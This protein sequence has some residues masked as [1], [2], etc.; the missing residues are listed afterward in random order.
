MN[1]I[2]HELEVILGPGTAE[3]GL[4]L[5]VHSGP[6]TAGVLRGEKSRFQLFGDTVNTAARMESTGERNKIQ[7]SQKT[8]ELLIAA[9][10]GEWIKPRDSLVVAKGKGK[11]QTFWLS[12]RT[13]STGSQSGSHTNSTSFLEQDISSNTGIDEV[14]PVVSKIEDRVVAANQNLVNWYVDFLQTL[15]K[16]VLATRVDPTLTEALV[17]TVEGLAIENQ[18]G[19]TL[20]EEMEEFVVLPDQP[21]AM[22]RDPE[23]FDLSPIVLGQLRDYVSTIAQLY[24][25]KPFHCFAHATH[26]GQSV[27]KL[28]SQMVK[29]ESIDLGGLCYK[30]T[31]CRQMLHDTTYGIATDPLVL[32][33][34]AF[35]ALIHDVDHSGVTNSQLVKEGSNM[36]VLYKNRCVS[37]QNSIDVAWEL[38]MEPNYK[39]LRACIYSN[40]SELHRFRQLVLHAVLATDDGDNEL[41]AERKRLWAEAFQGSAPSVESAPGSTRDEGSANANSNANAN[42]N[43][44]ATL[45]IERMIQAS[46]FAFAMQHWH[47][48]V[49]WNEMLFD[50]AYMSYMDG[51]AEI[52]PSENW[53]EQELEFFDTFI[54]PLAQNLKD[55]SVFGVV[56]DECVDY[57][58]ANKIEWSLK[59]K[60]MIE[61]YM[62]KHK[63]QANT[64]N[65]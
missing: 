8:A 5:G 35:S 31:R 44:K 27:A 65:G 9:G 23:S 54:I 28:L 55:C 42:A 47:V 12:P 59:G 10:K 3:L 4:R 57:A 16:K 64:S 53:Y 20:L 14:V 60:E 15:L 7:V 6:V 30:K 51:R 21:T 33:A 17:T 52:N 32:F 36:A 61:K 40:P 18:S 29:S 48:Y 62:S 56:I 45:V 22:L 58:E 39:E 11:L 38:L 63:Q 46:D 1:E 24:R 49:K 43:L 37:E 50:E 13:R 26:A 19:K 25:N 41:E 34:C 2:V